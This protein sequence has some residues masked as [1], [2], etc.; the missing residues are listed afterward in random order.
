MALPIDKTTYDDMPEGYHPWVY[1][2]R[3][4]SKIM[5]LFVNRYCEGIREHNIPDK[6][7]RF[8]VEAAIEQSIIEEWRAATP[9]EGVT[10]QQV[11][12]SIMDQWAT[13]LAECGETD[14]LR[15]GPEWEVEV[16][17]PHP[18]DKY[19]YGRHKGE[20][21]MQFTRIAWSAPRTTKWITFFK[22]VVPYMLKHD[23]CAVR[24]VAMRYPRQHAGRLPKLVNAFGDDE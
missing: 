13:Y 22:D 14:I 4:A 8:K 23:G 16:Y 2:H 5:M 12:D 3:D 17:L 20:P 19:T 7:P 18:T 11:M 9:R 6:L 24:Y 10:C 1:H 15:S 21:Y